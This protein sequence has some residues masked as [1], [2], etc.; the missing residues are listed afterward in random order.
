MSVQAP[1]K[2]VISL[3]GVKNLGA[4]VRGTTC[5]ATARA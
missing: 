2:K 1:E 3:I 5:S 4:G